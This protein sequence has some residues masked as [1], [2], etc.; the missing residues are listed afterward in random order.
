MTGKANSLEEL[1]SQLSG[2]HFAQDAMRPHERRTLHL[3]EDLLRRID[4]VLYLCDWAEN[5]GA[6]VGT[7]AIRDRLEEGMP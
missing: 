4:G 6:Q 7:V 3:A 2:L 1:R 5:I